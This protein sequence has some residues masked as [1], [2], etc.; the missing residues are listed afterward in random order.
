MKNKFFIFAAGIMIGGAV[1]SGI[2]WTAEKMSAD[3]NG[4][5]TASVSYKVDAEA[6]SKDPMEF[7]P[8]TFTKE[9][10]RYWANYADYLLHGG[11]N[12]TNWDMAMASGLGS[13]LT[14]VELYIFMKE[15]AR[16]LKGKEL[17]EF[18]AQ[19]RQWMKWLEKE[20]RKPVRDE[21]GNIIEGTMA[22]PLQAA[23]PQYLIEQYLNKFPDR[24][25][26]EHDYVA[27]YKKNRK[28]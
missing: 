28:K 22:I 24:A 20:S 18:V 3:K 14:R 13:F 21:K 6:D 10:C 4:K 12:H 8:P 9:N 23:K 27:E 11:Y 2:F 16:I 1:A 26:L 7:F 15:K 19:H 5:S 25:K 17:Q